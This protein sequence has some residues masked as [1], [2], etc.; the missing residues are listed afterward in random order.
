LHCAIRRGLSCMG[1]PR[2]V[3]SGEREVVGATG[4]A[5]H[6]YGPLA[7]SL[8]TGLSMAIA[9]HG[10]TGALSRSLLAL[11]NAQLGARPACRPQ[12]G[13]AQVSR[14]VRH[15]SGLRHGG[16]ADAPASSKTVGL[17]SATSGLAVH[18]RVG[19]GAE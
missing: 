17:G 14:V 10:G 5:L 4:A 6:R 7:S 18:R 11:S 3:L 2:A 8:A 15:P 12:P 1:P 9:Y 16:D 13:L 19:G